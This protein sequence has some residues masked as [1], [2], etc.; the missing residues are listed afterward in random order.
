MSELSRLTDYPDNLLM[1]A[2]DDLADIR[3]FLHNEIDA[4]LES[5]N[6]TLI[7]IDSLASLIRPCPFSKGAGGRRRKNCVNQLGMRLKRLALKFNVAIVHV[8]EISGII[9]EDKRFKLAINN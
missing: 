8:N 5:S 3:R 6:V 7:A 9:K 1:R 2:F 4:L